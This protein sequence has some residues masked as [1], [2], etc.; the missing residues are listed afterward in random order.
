[1]NHEEQFGIRLGRIN[2][3]PLSE[4]VWKQESNAKEKL[5][6]ISK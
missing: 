5:K 1:M 3:C 4:T 2:V 6:Q